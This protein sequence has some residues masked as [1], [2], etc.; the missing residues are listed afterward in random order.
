MD[1]DQ[2]DINP[3]ITLDMRPSLRPFVRLTELAP[4][5]YQLR[6]MLPL[7]QAGSLTLGVKYPI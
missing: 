7:S 4:Y 6:L 1:L 3:S 2:N 5:T